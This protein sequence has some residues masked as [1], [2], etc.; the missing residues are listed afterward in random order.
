MDCN[1]IVMRPDH[2]IAYKLNEYQFTIYRPKKK[3]DFIVKLVDSNLERSIGL[4]NQRNCTF[5]CTFKNQ[6]IIYDSENLKKSDTFD[7]LG[8]IKVFGNIPIKLE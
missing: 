4:K 5:L 3:H 8:K 2:S 1:Q 6:I 7:V